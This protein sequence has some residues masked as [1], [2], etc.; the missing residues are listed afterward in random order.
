MSQPV[1]TTLYVWTPPI[2][3]PICVELSDE[4]LQKLTEKMPS[5]TI[6]KADDT[7]PAS[8][9]ICWS[10]KHK[11]S[12]TKSNIAEIHIDV[13]NC[14]RDVVEKIKEMPEIPQLPPEWTP[15]KIR[16]HAIAYVKSMV[17]RLDIEITSDLKQEK[18]CFTLPAQW[19]FVGILKN[20]TPI[21]YEL[22]D[23]KVCVTVTHESPTLLTVQLASDT[24]QTIQATTSI[25]MS[26]VILLIVVYL[27][28]AI[29]EAFKR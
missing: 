12:I 14:I 11:F 26:V 7:K 29:I 27:I 20:N 24:T 19:R 8:L 1:F 21:D 5:I 17:D 4:D 23:N 16:D 3:F 18:F 9:K 22:S 10:D 2:Q 6:V 13:G 28:K 25:V 15:E